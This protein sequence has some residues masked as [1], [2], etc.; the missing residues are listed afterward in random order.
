[1]KFGEAFTE[2]LKGEQDRFLE[3]CCHVEYKNLKNVLK[4]CQTCKA[5]PDSCSPDCQCQ[6]C[7]CEFCFTKIQVFI[8]GC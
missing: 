1:M 3:K 4:T 7:P 2:Y 6:S 8:H 5:S